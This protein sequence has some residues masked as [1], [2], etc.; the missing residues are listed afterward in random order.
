M[1]KPYFESDHCIGGG[2][3][4][5]LEPR[6]GFDR[7]IEALPEVVERH[8]G[9]AFLIGGDGSDKHRLKT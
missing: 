3:L 6:K 2:S 7:V 1:V 8:P 5:R 4:A 9:A